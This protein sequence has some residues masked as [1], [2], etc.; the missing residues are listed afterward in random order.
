MEVSG[1][2]SQSRGSFQNMILSAEA[3]RRIHS[4]SHRQ[5]WAHHDRDS[6]FYSKVRTQS[7]PGRD[8]GPAGQEMTV[9]LAWWTLVYPKS[10]VEG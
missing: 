1:G 6:G 4:E 9:A 3:V 7:F 5:G 8:Q 2:Q 10:C